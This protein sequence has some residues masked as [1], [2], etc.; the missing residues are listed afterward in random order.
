MY[1]G[2]RSERFA[3]YVRHQPLL[4]RRVLAD[5]H[6]R[7]ADPRVLREPRLD[8]ARLDAEAA[9]LH[10]VVGAAQELQRPVR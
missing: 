2:R 1:S 3:R 8:L 5:E 6:H 7:R 9:H 10:L 4:A